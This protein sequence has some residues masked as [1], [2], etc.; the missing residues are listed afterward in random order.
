MQDILDDLYRNA[1]K[2]QNFKKLVRHIISDSNIKLAYRNLKRNKGSSTPGVN[3]RDI[4]DIA[5]KKPKELI[6]YVRNRLKNYIPNKVR[7]EY[8][9]KPDGRKRPLGIPVIEDRL[10][11][12]C[13]KQI[14]EPICESKFHN[15]SYGF[16][17]NRS[18]KDAIARC[19]FLVNRVKMRYTVDIDIK[20]FFDNVNHSKLLKQLWTMGIKD[21]NLL[22]IIKKIL[23]SEV[24]GEGIPKQ[25]TPQGGIISPLL[26]NVVLNEMDWWIS[27]QWETFETR[28]NYYSKGNQN[29]N[30]KRNSNLKQIYLVRYADDFKIFC[31]DYETAVKTK[32]AVTKWLKR[33]LDLEI[34]EKKSKITNLKKNYSKFLGIK[35]KAVKKNNTYV[36]KSRVDEERVI[37]VVD[38]LKSQIKVIQQ[39]T[40]AK[41]V[42]LLNTIILGLHNYYRVA[43]HVNVDFNYIGFLFNLILKNRLDNRISEKS[44]KVSETYEKFYG[45]YSYKKKSIAGVTIYPVSG[46]TTVPPMCYSQS[47]C[48]YTTKGR[49]KTHQRLKCVSPDIM[50]Y[51]SKTFLEN[52]TMEFNDNKISKYAGQYGSCYISKVPLERDNLII[53]RKT[54]KYKGGTDGYR[55]LML[56]TCEVKKLIH[57]RKRKTIEKYLDKIW[58]KRIDK[59][60][61]KRLNILRTEV[62]NDN[63]EEY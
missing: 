35:F 50:N 4:S 9:E 25:G 53:H 38:K 21:K 45:K 2:E 3:G 51:L 41:Q 17:S 19:M 26:S 52:E 34:S 44:K 28:H 27:D 16:R 7:R 10:I 43:T 29:A 1:N 46:V 60:S 31:P 22:Q 11:Q 61:L 55:N 49:E 54:P 6:T 5:Q 23:R 56:I 37:R 48:N 32:I 40:T 39:E 59:K 47:I 20:G 57:A 30:L 18:T 63:I 33:R 36:V 12:Q 24:E 8:I 42:R 13:I 62:G 15:H 58:N 14:L